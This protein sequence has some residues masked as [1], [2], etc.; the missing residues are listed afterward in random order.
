MTTKNA[1]LVAIGLVAMMVSWCGGRAM[2]Q[3][4]LDR[5]FAANTA[6]AIKGKF[7]STRTPAQ[8]GESSLPQSETSQ[9]FDREAGDGPKPEPFERAFLLT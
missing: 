1:P 2:S 8:I 7:K 4:P 6:H 3:I 5:N 9:C